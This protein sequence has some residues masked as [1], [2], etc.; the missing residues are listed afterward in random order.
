ML[1]WHCGTLP[2]WNL[3][4][5]EKQHAAAHVAWKTRIEY[6]SGWWSFSDDSLNPTILYKFA[7]LPIH[8]VNVL[9]LELRLTP[10]ASPGVW[11]ILQLSKP[12]A[13]PLTAS[14]M[15]FKICVHS[16]LMECL[17]RASQ[18]TCIWELLPARACACCCCPHQWDRSVR[19][20]P[21]CSLHCVFTVQ[22]GCGMRPLSARGSVL[23]GQSRV[24]H[25]SSALD[26]DERGD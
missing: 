10:K 7:T 9:I 24:E 8:P 26:R 13:S 20:M 18:G 6:K 22:R 1:P 23:R 15:Q 14:L 25:V 17:D 21:A 11:S 2:L 16:V 4:G 12:V 5:T 19:C 3:P